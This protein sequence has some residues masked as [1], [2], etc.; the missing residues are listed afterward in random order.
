MQLE[1]FSNGNSNSLKEEKMKIPK[2]K[3]L[4]LIGQKIAQFQGVLEKATYENRY[5]KKYELAYHGTETLLKELFSEEEAMNFRRNVTSVVAV[6]GGRTDYEEELKDYKE[7]ITSCIAQLEVYRERVSNFWLD[8]KNS[9]ARTHT[10]VIAKQTKAGLISQS[11]S[12]PDPKKIFVVH[13]RNEEAR[14]S[15]FTFLRA[16][17]LHPLEW[18]ELVKATGKGS[19]YIGEILEKG[20]S[21][22]KAVVVLMSPDYVG[23]L[24]KEFRRDGDPPSETELTPQARL[25]VIFEA[26][27]AF[28][29]CAES[30][31]IVELGSLRP[32]SDISGRHVV[33]LDNSTE[34]R[35]ELAQRLLTLG[36]EADLS[37]TDWHTAGDFDIKSDE[38]KDFEGLFVK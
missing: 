21:E 24:K 10:N 28:G 16:I 31:V 33:R 34:K 37:G 12:V 11:Q 29:Y 36:C 25:N 27:M 22:V 30:T 35:Q 19:P 26:G 38:E 32:F 5:D 14:V 3:A 23:K 8:E 7:H 20:F 17:G 6:V 4:E 9:K 18:T 15:L 13:G 1:H 2:N